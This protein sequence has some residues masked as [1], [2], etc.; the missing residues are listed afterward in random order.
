MEYCRMAGRYTQA[1]PIFRFRFGSRFLFQSQEPSSVPSLVPRTG[2][3]T[4]LGS[5]LGFYEEFRIFPRYSSISPILVDIGRY[6]LIFSVFLVGSSGTVL[7]SRAGSRTG[8]RT[9]L[10]SVLGSSQ[11]SRTLLRSMSRFISESKNIDPTIPSSVYTVQLY[12]QGIWMAKL[13]QI[14][15]IL[16]KKKSPV[17]FPL[18]CNISAFL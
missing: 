11:L 9:V 5:V 1:V 12:W 6:S 7:G 10:S 8:S 3:R 15:K 13:Y 16:N 4:V 17:F 2:S 18:F 14:N